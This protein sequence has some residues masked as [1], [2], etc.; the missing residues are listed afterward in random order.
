MV[1]R[2]VGRVLGLPY[3]FVDSISKMIPFD[4]SRPQS[5]TECINSEPRLQKLVNDVR[6]VCHDIVK[7]EVRR[8]ISE[9][10]IRPDG[11]GLAE[12]RP[13]HSKIDLFDRTHGSAMFTRGQTQALCL[14]TLGSLSEHKKVDGMGETE[15]K[16]F[17]LHYNFPPYSVGE[18]GRVGSPGRREVGHGKLAWRAINPLLPSGDDFPYTVRVVSEVTESNG[19]SS[20]ASVCGTS[21]ALM[22]A[23]VPIK[24]PVA[25]IAMGLIK[26]KKDFSVLSDLSVAS[27]ILL[28]SSSC[29]SNMLVIPS[30]SVFTTCFS[31]SKASCFEI[32]SF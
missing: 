14:T 4:P 23:G 11:R 21:L 31:F 15:Q 17:M 2:D 29:L 6:T 19:S 13:L 1:I 32:F 5:L 30:S 27:I 24:K 28:L 9:D 25:G 20:M 22:D 3:G 18:A 10:K 12:L 16:T 7:D 8:L 26:E